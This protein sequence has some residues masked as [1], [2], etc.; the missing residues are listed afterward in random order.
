MKNVNVKLVFGGV[1]VVLYIIFYLIL[2]K[3]FLLNYNSQ[4]HNH[5]IV[6]SPH[7]YVKT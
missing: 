4:P 6:G 3:I 2:F 5:G 1:R 7:I